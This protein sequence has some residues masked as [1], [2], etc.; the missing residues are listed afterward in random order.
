[1]TD[2][3]DVKA[4]VGFCRSAARKLLRENKVKEPGTRVETLVESL[5]YRVM[6]R[7]WPIATSGILLREHQVIGVNANHATVRKRF[8]IAHELGH[9]C[10]GH[11]LWFEESHKVTIDSPPIDSCEGPDT[12]P[13]REAN[14]F[15][16]ELLVPLAILKREAKKGRT[17]QALAQM[18]IV[19][20]QT[21]FYAL[22][23]HRL[24]GRL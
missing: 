10:L 1:M 14:V 23:D 21:M 13:E 20:D 22:Q 3:K 5:G 11:H 4:R 6:E 19:S 9:H 7:D 16:S 12:T 2:S 17:P 8:T 15:A 18:F 24:L